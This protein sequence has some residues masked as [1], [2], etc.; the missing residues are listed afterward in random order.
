[1]PQIAPIAKAE[2]AALGA[3]VHLVGTT[4]D[5]SLAAAGERA[6]AGGLTFVHPF[7]DADVVAGQGRV[8]LELLD[9]VPAGLARVLVTVGGGGLVSGIAIAVKSQRP[10]IEVI[11]V[12][13]E[14][15]APVRASL[16]AGAPVEVDSALTIA[17]GIAVKRPGEL[18]RGLIRRWGR[19]HSRRGRGR[20]GGGDDVR[21]EA[22][23]AGR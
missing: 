13:V 15:C 20:C 23:Q 4:V 8:G 14:T 2:A 5:E 11:G 12:Q 22:G 7:D 16:E 1:M 3:E 21:A 6:A 9:Q 18:T 10:E 19:R 17:D